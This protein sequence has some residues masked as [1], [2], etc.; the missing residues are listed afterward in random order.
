VASIP[1]SGMTATATV[2]EIGY[3]FADVFYSLV[4]RL[5]HHSCVS[6][7]FPTADFGEGI[8]TTNTVMITTLIFTHMPGI[9]NLILNVQVWG[10]HQ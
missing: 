5:R 4:S 8:V 7:I 2:N 1:L 3:G 10:I 9:D 6:D